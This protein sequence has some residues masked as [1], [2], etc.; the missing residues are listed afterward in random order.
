VLSLR[1]VGV[2]MIPELA[3]EVAAK[4][5][6]ETPQQWGYA[7]WEH[8]N[9]IGFLVARLS[10]WQGIGLMVRKMRD[11]GFEEEHQRDATDQM[12]YW[13]FRRVGSGYDDKDF[14]MTTDDDVACAR[15][16]LAALAARVPA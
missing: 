9:A 12:S 10:G 3:R 2:A 8:P 6:G 1:V 5:L 15:A 11:E 7:N 16:A 4:V 14:R 13:R